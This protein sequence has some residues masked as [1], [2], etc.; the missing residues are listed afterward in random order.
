MVFSMLGLESQ[1]SAT[2]GDL[3]NIGTQG[4]NVAL[5]HE[6]RIQLSK[7]SALVFRTSFTII[8]AFILA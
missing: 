2:L 8:K 5:K 4:F 1:K 6:C 3:M 7:T